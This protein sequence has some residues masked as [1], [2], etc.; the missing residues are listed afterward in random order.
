MLLSTFD[1]KASQPPARPRDGRQQ[2]AGAP[3][4][5]RGCGAEGA[6]PSPL[7]RGAGEGARDRERARGSGDGREDGGRPGAVRASDSEGEADP[8]EPSC[9]LGAAGPAPGRGAFRRQG[10]GRV[11]AGGGGRLGPGA[12][13][14]VRRAEG[15]GRCSAEAE[16]GG[17]G[18]GARGRA[19]A[20]D[21]LLRPVR[22]LVANCRQCGDI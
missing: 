14:G 18:P 8:E 12:E 7:A 10:G 16:G 15:V 22:L 5:A 17:R 4:L 9:G 19:R 2:A 6:G 11:G 1:C 3:G 21:H 20:G 13:G